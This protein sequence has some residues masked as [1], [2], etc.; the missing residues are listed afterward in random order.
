MMALLEIFFSPGKVFD[1]IRERRIFLPALV[2]VMLLSVATFA[3]LA[4]MVG[5]QAMARKQLESSSRTASMTA[6]QK[7]AAIAQAGSPARLYVTCGAFFIGSAVIMLAIAGIA[8]GGLAAA[9]GKVSYAQVL[10]VVCYV[11]VPFTLLN[12]V[13]TA[14]VLYAAPDRDSLDFNNLI[15]TNIGAFLNNET[16]GKMIYSIAGSIDLIS[17]AHIGMLG[18]GFS[19]VSRLSFATCTFIV[20]AM[21]AV[22]V[23]GK[24]GLSV[25]F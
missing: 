4:N 1:E 13:M 18:W 22:Y 8:L 15:A 16:T 25:L 10:G 6:E 7:D 12:L 2:A 23:L 3:V 9:G 14:A 5:M 24:A 19:R 17:F 20:I 21:W 11:G